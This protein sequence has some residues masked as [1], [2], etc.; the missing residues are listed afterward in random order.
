MCCSSV[1]HGFTWLL[2]AQGNGWHIDENSG[3]CCQIGLAEVIHLLSIP[4][5]S[6]PWFHKSPCG[7]FDNTAYGIARSLAMAWPKVWPLRNCSPFF[8]NVS[9]R[10]FPLI[11]RSATIAPLNMTIKLLLLSYVHSHFFI[12]VT[13][14]M[15]IVLDVVTQYHHTVVHSFSI[16]ICIE[17]LEWMNCHLFITIVCS[18]G[19]I[20]VCT[21]V[22]FCEVCNWHQGVG[23]HI[24]SEKFVLLKLPL[25]NKHVQ[26]VTFQLTLQILQHFHSISLFH[27][28]CLLAELCTI[29]CCLCHVLP[30]L[31]LQLH[32]PRCLL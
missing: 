1:N 17:T 11:L 15:M 26:T 10:A 22:I 7:I 19:L 27:N 5:N 30:F 3:V 16:I 14:C 24:C 12:E 2:V 18:T 32:L 4:H 9:E 8:F 31:P 25:C 28:Q 23:R 20:L 6:S 21:P 13:D 29:L